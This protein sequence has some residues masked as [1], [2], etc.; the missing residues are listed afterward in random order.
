MPILFITSTR[1]TRRGI[2]TGDQQ[3]VGEDVRLPVGRL[4]K[5]A[6]VRL[7]LVLAEEG[8]HL[9]QADRPF[10]G[11]GEAGYLLALDQRL[12]VGGL[13]V[14]SPRTD[15]PQLCPFFPPTAD[16]AVAVV[17]SASPLRRER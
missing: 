9:G 16:T 17:T 15:P 4:G 3:T 1:G 12:T 2:L 5:D 7:Q 10:F 11:V 6:A 14:T 8:H 13:D